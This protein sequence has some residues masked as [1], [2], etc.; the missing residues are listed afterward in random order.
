[1]K[2]FFVPILLIMAI[3]YSSCSDARA[4]EIIL[5]GN[6]KDTIILNSKYT[7]PGYT[8]NDKK[9]GNISHKVNVSGFVNPDKTGDYYVLYS[10]YDK[11]GNEGKAERT[12]HVYNQAKYLE[13]KYSVNETVS[14]SNNANYTYS[15]TVKQSE[16]VN[17]EIEINN[18]GAFGSYVNVKAGVSGNII[19]IKRQTPTGMPLGSEGE[20]VGE[21]E[22]LGNSIKNIIYTIYYLNGQKDSI[23]CLYQRQ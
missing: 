17:N 10:V 6:T 3:I 5:E 8:A 13:G 11:S 1:M 22:I 18:F 15:V 21:G 4:P 9:D 7:E 2:L 16:S 23:V 20:I 19:T 14:G 12:V